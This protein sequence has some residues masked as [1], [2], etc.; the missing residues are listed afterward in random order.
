M[1]VQIQLRRD[2]AAN[3]LLNDPVL[4]EGEF[5]VE[6]DGGK[7]KIGDGS[8]S[9]SALPYAASTPAEVAEYRQI[10][11]RDTAANLTSSNPTP[12]AGEWGY[13]TDTGNVKIGD[14]STAW[15]S[16]RYFLEGKPT[17]FVQSTQPSMVPG[18]LWFD[19]AA[20]V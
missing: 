5:G 6:T 1:S 9:W 20:Q 13:E 3:W 11:L 15:N 4:A 19:T 10:R 7:F 17:M 8:S 18:D 12:L 16:L 2:T 14:G